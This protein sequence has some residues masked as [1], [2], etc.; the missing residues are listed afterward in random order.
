MPVYL[1]RF[2]SESLLKEKEAEK[3]AREKTQSSMENQQRSAVPHPSARKR[4]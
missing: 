3:S 1:R 4:F 2:Y